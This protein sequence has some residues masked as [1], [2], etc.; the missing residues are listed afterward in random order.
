MLGRI[1]AKIEVF[2]RAHKLGPRM[3]YF[4]GHVATGKILTKEG[5]D[6]TEDFGTRGF[7]TGGCWTLYD[8]DTVLCMETRDRDIIARA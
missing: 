2:R 4:T 1:F 8:L 7:S 6:D 5:N 3:G